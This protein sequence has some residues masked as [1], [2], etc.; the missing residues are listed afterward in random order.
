MT[1][2]VAE[3]TKVADEYLAT[4]AKVQ[5]QFVQ[6]VE[7]FVNNLPELP[8]PAVELPAFELPADLPK[9]QDIT[10]AGFDF[11][12]KVLAQYRTTTDKLVA[13][14]PAV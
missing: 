1:D 8:K 9:A 6:A 3:T 11:A 10:A 2:Y 14:V 13:L 4:V 7:A 12:E 5:E